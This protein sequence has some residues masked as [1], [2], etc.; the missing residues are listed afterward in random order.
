MLKLRFIRTIRG[1]LSGIRPYVQFERVRYSSHFLACSYE[2][3]GRKVAVH[4]TSDN[5]QMVTAFLLE[6][7][8]DG[9]ELGILIAKGVWGRFPHTLEMRKLIIA[10]KCQVAT[11][12]LQ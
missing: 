10:K 8:E 6:G 2:L 12:L 3:I 9:R 1:S 7:T 5:C 11:Q 4:V